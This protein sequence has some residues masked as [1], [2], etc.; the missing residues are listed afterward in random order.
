[1]IEVFY[2]IE[3][4][5]VPRMMMFNKSSG[6]LESRVKEIQLEPIWGYNRRQD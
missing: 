2:H 4:P 5:G 1:V 6:C 3:A